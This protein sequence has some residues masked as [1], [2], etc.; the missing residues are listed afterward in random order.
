[1][2]QRVSR[3]DLMLILEEWE[4]GEFGEPE[5]RRRLDALELMMSN[6]DAVDLIHDEELS[7]AQIADHI[8]GYPEQD[9]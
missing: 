5:L 1:M 7:S 6:D 2:S 8:L 9:A 3:T 4:R